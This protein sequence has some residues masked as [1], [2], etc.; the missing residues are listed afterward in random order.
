MTVTKKNLLANGYQYYKPSPTETHQGL[1]QKSIY[2]P[3]KQYFIN[4]Y[5]YDFSKFAEVPFDGNW[6]SHVQFNLTKEEMVDVSFFIENDTELKRVEDFYSE[7]YTKFN[8]NSCD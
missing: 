1:Y 7:F 8:C 4:I 6:H 2:N 5:Y 3:N